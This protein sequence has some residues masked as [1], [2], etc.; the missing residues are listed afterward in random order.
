MEARETSS[1]RGETGLEIIQVHTLELP[2]MLKKPF[3][4]MMYLLLEG[5]LE[6]TLKITQILGELLKGLKAVPL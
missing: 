6:Q 4:A 5:D 2:K 3:T 1:I